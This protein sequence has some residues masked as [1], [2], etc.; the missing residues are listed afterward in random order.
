MRYAHAVSLFTV[1]ASADLIVTKGKSFRHEKNKKKRGSYRGGQID[2][3][4]VNSVK[5]T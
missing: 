4:A 1:Q 2:I 5:K 3:H